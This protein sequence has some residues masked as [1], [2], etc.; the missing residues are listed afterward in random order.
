MI[1]IIELHVVPLEEQLFN[2]VVY[3]SMHVYLYSKCVTP[4]NLSASEMFRKSMQF[5]LRP[6]SLLTSLMNAH[7]NAHLFINIDINCA[8]ESYSIELFIYST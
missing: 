8:K 4:N 2:C 3:K 7:L 5:V 1:W 6:S